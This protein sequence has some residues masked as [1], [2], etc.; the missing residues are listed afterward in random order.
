MIKNGF[1]YTQFVNDDTGEVFVK[2]LRIKNWDQI[3]VGI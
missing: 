3:K 1:F 2:R